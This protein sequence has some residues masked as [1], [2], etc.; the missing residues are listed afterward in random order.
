MHRRTYYRLFNTAAGAQEC[1]IAL[2]RDYLRRHDPGVSPEEKVVGDS[3]SMRQ[4]LGL[5]LQ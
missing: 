2:S 5:R 3:A 4:G 1:W